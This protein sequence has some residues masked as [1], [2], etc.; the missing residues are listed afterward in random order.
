MRSILE[1]TTPNTGGLLTTAEAR[2]SLGLTDGSRD[3][4]LDRMIARIS[5]GI[6]KACK[7]A[8][9]GIHAPTLLSESITETFRLQ[10]PLHASIQLSR[11][12]VS[13]VTTVTEGSTEL[14]D[15]DFDIERASGLLSRLGVTDVSCWPKGVVV[16]DYIAGFLTVP[17]DLKLAAETWLRI[18]WRDAYQTPSNISD[19]FEK[20]VDI[21]GV[22][23]VERWVSQ[24]TI[25]QTTMGM[26]PE[27]ET[28]LYEGGYIET[29]VA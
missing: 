20:V 4:D 16:V 28:L 27:V 26:P 3:A 19:P 8:S 7:V 10:Y 13:E 9:D 6:Y 12:R 24:M 18:L 5:A 14:T 23:R 2:L 29:W 25:N 22:E 15:D 11:R 1:V 17:A 21:P